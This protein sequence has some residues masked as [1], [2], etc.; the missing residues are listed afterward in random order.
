LD[1]ERRIYQL[2]KEEMLEK[3]RIQQLKMNEVLEMQRIQRLVMGDAKD[4]GDSAAGD[5]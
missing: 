4:A 5:G 1:E 3:Q 2:E